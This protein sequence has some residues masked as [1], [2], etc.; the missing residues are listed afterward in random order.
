[1]RQGFCRYRDY[2]FEM[3]KL[4]GL[5]FC[6]A[7][8]AML[9]LTLSACDWMDSSAPPRDIYLSYYSGDAQSGEEQ[10]IAEYVSS[11][12]RG[13]VVTVISEDPSSTS[14]AIYSGIIINTDGLVLTAADAAYFV[15]SSGSVR[16]ADVSAVLSEIYGDS[17]K[18]KLE[19]IDYDSDAG[20][21]LFSFYDRFYHYTDDEKTSVADGFQLYATLSGIDLKVGA[22]CVA[23]GNAAGEYYNGNLPDPFYIRETVTSG[24]VSAMSENVGSVSVGEN[25][26]NKFTFSAP[27]TPELFG[28]ALFDE[29][30][31]LIGMISDKFSDNGGNVPRIAAAIPSEAIAAYFDEV[32][33]RK[34]IVVEYSVATDGAER[35]AVQLCGNLSEAA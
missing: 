11:V 29:N 9:L 16:T 28:G 8:S 5:A 17:T 22:A 14:T 30:G 6:F 24:V 33:L 34:Q 32:S 18:Y 4:F 19:L 35:S 13:A 3:K 15:R 27:S 10:D 26:Y 23:I 7:L 25:S 2:E 1:M 21:A 31:Y 20:L 12:D